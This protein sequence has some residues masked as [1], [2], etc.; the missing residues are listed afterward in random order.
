MHLLLM[1]NYKI[2]GIPVVDA[3]GYLVGIVTNRD[4][5]FEKNMDR[6]IAEVMTRIIWSL[7]MN[8]PTLRR[9]LRFC[10]AIKLKSCR[11]WIRTAN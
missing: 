3:S 2:G 7:P 1:G 5:R 4:L 9:P 8:R 6:P 10:R 11:C